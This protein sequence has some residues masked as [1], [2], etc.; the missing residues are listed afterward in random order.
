MVGRVVYSIWCFCLRV[1]CV[2]WVGSFVCC[3]VALI[4]SIWLGVPKLLCWWRMQRMCTANGS[5]RGLLK[6]W[7]FVGTSYVMVSGAKWVGHVCLGMVMCVVSSFGTN[8]YLV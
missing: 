6:F 2:M 4:V 7:W 3:I 8:L 1:Y 5:I